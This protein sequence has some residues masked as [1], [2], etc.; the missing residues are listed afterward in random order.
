MRYFKKN[1]DAKKRVPNY[2][3]GEDKKPT[4]SNS[5]NECWICGKTGHFAR[6]CSQK[7]NKEIKHSVK[8]IE[9]MLT[10]ADTQDLDLIYNIELSDF[11]IYDNTS[12]YTTESDT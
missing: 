2:R 8:L 9:V 5:K 10:Q 7:E 12:A 3:K 6:S 11:E 1:S 4:S